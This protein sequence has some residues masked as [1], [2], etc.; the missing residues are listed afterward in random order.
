MPR[1]FALGA[2]GLVLLLSGCV[3][4][5][6][7]PSSGG[8][9]GGP[10]VPRGCPVGSPPPVA[11]GGYYTNGTTVCSADGTPHLF[12]GVDRPSLEWGAGEHISASDFQTMADWHAN[13][14]RVGLNQDF[15][16]AG[17]AL[18]MDSYQDRVDQVVHFAESVGLDVILDLHWSDHG[19]LS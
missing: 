15:W 12:H 6:P 4:S 7:A 19:D 11:P 16:L 2:L 17:A 14:V 1:R 5:S 3:D 18:H 9:D 13:V 10:V 8:G